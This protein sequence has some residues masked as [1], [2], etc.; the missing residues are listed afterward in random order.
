MKV[1]IHQ[2]KKI[3]NHSSL[4]TEIWIKYCQE[5]YIDFKVLDCYKNGILDDLKTYDV[6]LWHISNYSLQDMLFA[7]KILYSAKKL[8]I[9]VFPDF[10]LSW[11]FD[12]KIAEEYL[13]SS[14]NAPKPKSWFFY[15][16]DDAIRFLKSECSYP[17]VAKLK[18]GSGSNN[19]HLLA[20]KTSALR[21]AK[22]MFTSGFR[23]SPKLYFKLKSNIK[24]SSSWNVFLKRLK[25]V[26]DFLHSMQ[27]TKNFPREKGYLYLQEFIPNEGY[28][29]KVVVV[30]DKV[31]F[32]ARLARKNDFR[33]SGG[34]LLSYDKELVTKEIRTIARETSKK[35]G[36]I[37]MGYDFVVDKRNG[38]PLIIEISYGFSNLAQ[39]NL[40]GYWDENDVWV[41][42]PLTAPYEIIKSLI[43]KQEITK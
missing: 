22:K 41:D 36:F 24:S 16:K 38:K 1:A 35:C 23:S 2:N 20:N 27:K 26:P 10:N 37:C 40:G 32:V 33:A 18:S 11:H 29:L 13:L 43:K 39:E 34:G 31:S 28:D 15:V 21:Y 17:V 3:F 12:D 7:R 9:A 5:N 42:K 14:I 6:L 4:W 19:V 8:G 30:N 25:R